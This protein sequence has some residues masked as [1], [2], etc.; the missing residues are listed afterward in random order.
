[1]EDVFQ[2]LVFIAIAASVLI[3]KSKEVKT[4][5]P[6]K[7]AQKR[8]RKPVRK[9]MTDD[10]NDIDREETDM[11]EIFGQ[12]G[13]ILNEE[14]NLKRPNQTESSHTKP[15]FVSTFNNTCSLNDMRTDNRSHMAENIYA[16]SNK[17][18]ATSHSY[19]T[20]TSSKPHVTT[21]GVTSKKKAK[22]RLKTP[23][24]ARLA[25]IHSE[26]FNRKYN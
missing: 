22:I 17:F 9:P 12:F 25:F 10:E 4:N 5:H 8:V 13:S 2:V 26:I 7:H 19:P 3:G 15:S 16:A 14:K 6:K 24:E 21:R 1:M 23:Q 11:F 20:H 18:A